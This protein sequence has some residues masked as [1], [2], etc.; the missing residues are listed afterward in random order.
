MENGKKPRKSSAS[1]SK[2]DNIFIDLNIND[3]KE[4][5]VQLDVINY[6]NTM[7]IMQ[8]CNTSLFSD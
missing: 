7:S 2:N 5:I 4:D 1:K 3:F 6:N 8:E